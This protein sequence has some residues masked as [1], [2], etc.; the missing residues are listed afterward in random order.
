MPTDILMPALSPTMEEGKLAKWLVKEGDDHLSREISLPKSKLTRPQWKSK[1]STRAK[2]G[3][4]FSS[5]SG[6][7]G[8]DGVKVNTVIR[9]A[10]P[11]TARMLA[12]AAESSSVSRKQ[13]R[14]TA[15]RQRP[16]VD[17]EP[18]I[19]PAEVTCTSAVRFQQRCLPRLI[20]KFR[21]ARK[22]I[23]Q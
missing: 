23:E 10:L 19:V 14:R 18:A 13:G 6:S 5:M 20:R 1:L 7:E 9:S 4:R 8:T 2:S 17:P 12:A 16:P 3:C 22:C 11:L 21:K 15:S